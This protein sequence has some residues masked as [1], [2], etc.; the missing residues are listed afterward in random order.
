M[1]LI[2]F[3]KALRLFEKTGIL[4]HRQIIKKYTFCF[5]PDLPGEL[6]ISGRLSHGLKLP[7]NTR[8]IGI[9]SRFTGDTVAVQ[10]NSGKYLHNTV[11]LSGP[12]P[13][14][15]ILKKKVISVFKESKLPAVILEGRPGKP[16]DVYKNGNLTFYSHLP[17]SEMKEMITRSRSIITRSGY[18]TIMELISLNRSALLIPTPGQTEQEYLAEYLAEKGWFKTVSQKNLKIDFPLPET[19]A[20][21]SD[22]IITRSRKL[23]DEALTDLSEQCY[24]KT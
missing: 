2:P 14:R 17:A 4:L 10:R 15:S 6:N 9:L 5:V 22:E 1:P 8:Y 16:A 20:I 3:P 12:E 19:N 11:I 13:Q 24:K 23:L 21:W 7:E 18:S